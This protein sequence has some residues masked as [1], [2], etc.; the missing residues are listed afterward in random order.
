MGGSVRPGF[1]RITQKGGQ[2]KV[3][4]GWVG[5][6]LA[7]KTDVVDISS[8]MKNLNSDY[9]GSMENPEVAVAS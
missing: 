9:E 6:E 3:P 7:R 1:T 4:M 5:L 8:P 2:Q